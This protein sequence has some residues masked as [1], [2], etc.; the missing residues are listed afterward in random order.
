MALYRLEGWVC[1]RLSKTLIYFILCL[2]LVVPLLA[3]DEGRPLVIDAG[4]IERLQ[5]INRIDFEDL[6]ESIT[7]IENGWFV[8]SD[9]L[10]DLGVVFALTNRNSEIAILDEQSNVMGIYHIIGAD[11]LSATVVDMGFISS[12][13]DLISLHTDGEQYY[14]AYHYTAGYTGAQ[15]TDI[16]ELSFAGG[17]PQSTWGYIDTEFPPAS[18]FT[19]IEVLSEPPYTLSF[20]TG[21]IGSINGIVRGSPDGP[22]IVAKIVSPNA[23]PEAVIRIG[24]IEPPLAVTVTEDG[25]VKRWNMESG[26]VTAEVQVEDVLPI[27]GQLNVGGERYLVWRDPQSQA[28]HVLDFERGEDRIVTELNGA[29]IPF[30]FLTIQAD[31]IIGVDLDDAPVVVAWDVVTGVRYDLGEYRACNRP[32]DMVRL[33]Q[34][35]T[36]LVIGCD[37]GLDIWRVQ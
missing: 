11:N 1:R 26:E 3:Q 19:Y 29:Y 28:L 25:R 12:S 14:V 13:S 20:S 35:G 31:V 27:Y 16:V 24:R 33:S 36:T 23:D 6:P 37:T 32:P 2:G 34:D 21:P 7:P 10:G 8:I 22:P 5:S 9:Y 18:Y 17:I 4:N 15:D 30:T